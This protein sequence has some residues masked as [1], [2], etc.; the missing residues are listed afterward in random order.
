M[1]LF[2][3]NVYRQT[4]FGAKRLGRFVTFVTLILGVTVSQKV[5]WGRCGAIWNKSL[6]TDRQTDGHL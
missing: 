3:I 5:L 6:R 2:G 4:A 1:G